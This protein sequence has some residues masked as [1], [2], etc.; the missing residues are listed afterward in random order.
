MKRIFLT[1]LVTLTA[2]TIYAQKPDK[3]KELLKAGKLSEAKTEIDNFLAQEKNAKN[4]D[5]LYTK[6]KIYAAISFDANLKTQVPNARMTAFESLKKYTEVD[7]K[8]LI[9]LQIDGYK[10]INDIYTGYYQEAANAFNSKDYE[11]AFKDFGNAMTISKF[12]NEK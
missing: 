6:A 11:A 7:D 10:P 3:A 2:F 12:M 9:A 4:A 8:M 5:A 1:A